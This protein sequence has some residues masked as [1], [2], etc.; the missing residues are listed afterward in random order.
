MK[1]YTEFN[2]QRVCKVQLIGG[3]IMQTVYDNRCGSL[4]SRAHEL[5]IE[6][7]LIGKPLNIFYLTGIMIN[8]YERFLALLLD[9]K[10]NQC[11][12]ILPSLEKGIAEKQ[13]IPEILIRDDEDPVKKLAGV[14][15]TCNS[16]A[17]EMDYFPM[18]F[19]EKLKEYSQK[20]LLMDCSGMVIAQR[21]YKDDKEIEMIQMAAHYGDLVLE[22]TKAFIREGNT[23][24]QLQFELFRAM[25]I[26]PGVV[27]DSFIIQV[28]SGERSANPHGT[29]GDRKF[30]KGDPVTIDY[31]VNYQ[32]YWSDY[33]RTFFL[34]RPDSRL[35]QIYNVVLAAQMAAIE[36]VRPGIPVK[37]I[38]LTARQIIEKAG[39]GDQFIHRTGHGLGIDI[40][41][42]PKIHSTSEETLKEGM[43]FTIE[44]GIYIPGLGGVRIEDD[45]VVTKN[46][47]KVLNK[48]PKGLSD[49]ILD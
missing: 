3:N 11:T 44:P 10:N 40:H 43:V 47:V 17:L 6:K 28:L 2:Y 15:G 22:E 33:C 27:T 39:Y 49:M 36:K 32:N 5:G 4:L 35:E 9:T 31:G 12:M 48:F 29:A 41:E 37:F 20:I 25:S 45:V 18:A 30:Q 16:V 24:K 46:G 38:D 34:G 21:M 7:I 1:S 26:K 23:E 14:L 8:P 13:Q 42:N 19:G